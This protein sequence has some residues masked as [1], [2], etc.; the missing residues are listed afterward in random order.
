MGGETRPGIVHRLDKDTSG[1]LLVARNDSFHLLLAREFAA[2]RIQKTYLTLVHGQLDG[3]SGHISLSIARDLRR[4]TRM[5][6]RRR[7]GRAALTDWRV[8]AR[9]GEDRDGFTLVEADLHTGRTHQIRVHFSAIG[10]PVAGDT[11]YGAPR[12]VL[13]AGEPMDPLG[14]QWLHAARVRLAHPRT[15]RLLDIRAPLPPELT[16]WLSALARRLGQES[17][18]IDRVLDAYL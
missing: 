1:V 3:E 6:T 15:G 12:R 13:V 18:Q 11:R 9:L 2:R 14:R 7:E 8:L 5:T 4:R 10:H 17:T 16:G